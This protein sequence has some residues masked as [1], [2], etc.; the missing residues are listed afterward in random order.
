M[1]GDRR[2]ER[3]A[4]RALGAEASA[5]LGK[6]EATGTSNPFSSIGDAGSKTVLRACPVPRT[7]TDRCEWFRKEDLPTRRAL[8]PSQRRKGDQI[9]QES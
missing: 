5:P 6:S 9:F 2:L 8:S 3:P 4:C 7:R 1:P